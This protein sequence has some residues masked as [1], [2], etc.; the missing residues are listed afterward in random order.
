MLAMCKRAAARLDI[1]WPVAVA[2]APSS[3]YK[4][5][6]FPLTRSAPKQPLPVFPELLEEL[7]RSWADRPYSCEAMEKLHLLRFPHNGTSRGFPP[8]LQRRPG[9]TAPL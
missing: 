6:K 5:K 1:P 3:P 2:E 4:G 9:A 7:S 8:S